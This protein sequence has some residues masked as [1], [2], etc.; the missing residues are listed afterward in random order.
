[1]PCAYFRVLQGEADAISGEWAAALQELAA[2]LPAA[3]GRSRFAVRQ[4]YAQAVANVRGGKIGRSRELIGEAKLLAQNVA[5][6]LLPEI[7]SF[8]ATIMTPD[9]PGAAMPAF[10]ALLRSARQRGNL[11]LEAAA[12]GNIAY[13]LLYQGRVA[14]ALDQYEQSRRV[15]RRAAHAENYKTIGNIA[16]CYRILGDY[17][18]AASLYREALQGATQQMFV[19][20]RILW[21]TG[22]AEIE[23]QTG[24]LQAARTRLG[25]ALALATKRSLLPRVASTAA[26]L[27]SL[28][29]AMK[30]V[31]CAEQYSRTAMRIYA[32]LEKEERHRLE[33]SLLE[34]QL[35][36]GREKVARVAEQYRAIAAEAKER[37]IPW[38]R[39]E[40]QALLAMMY[41]RQGQ[42]REA[43]E[44]FREA[45]RTTD[46]ARANAS[47]D[48]HQLT[49]DNLV[50]SFFG[51][52]IRFL[53]AQKH[54]TEALAIAEHARA[55]TLEQALG[56]DGPVRNGDPRDAARA[57]GGTVLS[58]WLGDD[59][60]HL[61]VI[62]AKEVRRIDLPPRATIEQL[63]E[64]HRRDIDSAADF[65]GSTAGAKLY[66]LLVAPAN[67]APGTRVAIIPSRRLYELNFETL[68]ASAP[69]RHFWIED[70]TITTTSSLA[71]LAAGS[72]RRPASG[73]E[74][75]IV[76]D[77]PSPDPDHFAPLPKAGE[78]V[79]I[80]RA[81]FP[82]SVVLRGPRAT[83]AA[84]RE[85][86]PEQFAFLHF[87]AHGVPAAMK[88]LDSSIILARDD[89]RSYRLLA[90]D[91]IH[92]PSL[93]ARLVTI[94]A[95]HGA[96]VRAYAGEGLVGLAWAFLRAGSHQVIAALWQVNDG[97]TPELMKTMYAA[98][99]ERR[100]AASALREAKLALL[101]SGTINRYP[102]YWAPFV[103]Y[104]G[105]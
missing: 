77:V 87:V 71:V 49:F 67:V 47:D 38:L 96:G 68:I 70:V 91:V 48:D 10:E 93:H 97:A 89:P 17:D 69:R 92:M 61:W 33:A 103:L 88:P 102:K 81:Q 85:A 4:L 30:D 1:M 80:V 98:I 58:Y 3:L 41:A 62:T 84:Y 82:K 99:R 83:P 31:P 44:Q 95:C 43:D 37:N 57:F 45:L 40:A 5:P 13:V 55:Q 19:D 74:M 9:N 18:L 104:S 39:W 29:L 60:S 27:A 24:D 46:I 73:D 75:L 21:M 94:S 42:A 54:D 8:E 35:A 32:G 105:A 12:F 22:L 6:E 2:P 23:R 100:D 25:E 56:I 59:G 15:F 28:C 101:R 36:E 14:E 63:V 16:N 11:Y 51:T 20:D 65:L 64:R 7:G 26:D 52:Y 50:T 76:G 72:T 66:E 53:A 78:E 86:K 90:R 79:G 34:P